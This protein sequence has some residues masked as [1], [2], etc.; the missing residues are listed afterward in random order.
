MKQPLFTSL[1]LAVWMGA[2]SCNGDEGALPLPADEARQDPNDVEPCTSGHCG[3]GA[4]GDNPYCG[5]DCQRLEQL[6]QGC[7][8]SHTERECT[9]CG[10]TYIRVG[11]DDASTPFYDDRGEMVAIQIIGAGDACADAWYGIDLSE[12][13]PTGELRQV[14]CEGQGY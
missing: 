11:G 13:V 2:F 3:A 8:G 6:S 10:T 5:S 7:I 9:A 12:C 14:V 1:S 4:L